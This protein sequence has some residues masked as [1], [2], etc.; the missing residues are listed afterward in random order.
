MQ[1][2]KLIRPVAEFES[3]QDQCGS[4]V[5]CAPL[6]SDDKAITVFE[7][8]AYSSRPYCGIQLLTMYRYDSEDYLHNVHIKSDAFVKMQE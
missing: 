4:Y 2:G 8:Y 6:D 3:K 1:L 5:A 7:T